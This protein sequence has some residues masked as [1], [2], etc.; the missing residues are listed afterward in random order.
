MVTKKKKKKKKKKKTKPSPVC[1]IPLQEITLHSA[2][3]K[4]I[5]PKN[6]RSFV[7][8]QLVID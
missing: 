4:K 2:G 8:K 5:I 7:T 3:K 6:P 1:S